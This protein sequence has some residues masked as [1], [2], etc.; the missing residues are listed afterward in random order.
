MLLQLVKSHTGDSARTYR[1]HR[2]NKR[3]PGMIALA[4]R[5]RPVTRSA[6]LGS[7]TAFP[8]ACPG[9]LMPGAAGSEG[10]NETAVQ[11]VATLHTGPIVTL[12]ESLFF[13]QAAQTS[14]FVAVH[15]ECTPM[16]ARRWL[17]VSVAP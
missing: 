3:T 16:S 13:T 17:P 9:S 7:K 10:R 11:D 5:A 15:E 4:T 14:I 12:S 8:G 2:A 6:E 1:N